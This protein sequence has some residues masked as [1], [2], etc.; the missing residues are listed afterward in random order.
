MPATEHARHWAPP[1]SCHVITTIL[2]S[3]IWDF[4]DKLLHSSH[5]WLLGLRRRWGELWEVVSI[6]EGPKGVGWIITGSPQKIS[7]R[8]SQSFLVQGF[9]FKQVLLLLCLMFSCILSRL[10]RSFHNDR[11]NEFW[12]TAIPRVHIFLTLQKLPLP[13]FFLLNSAPQCVVLQYIALQCNGEEGTVLL[14]N[15]SRIRW[16]PPAHVVVVQ[17]ELARE[18]AAAHAQKC[19][20]SPTNN[21]TTEI[22]WIWL[23]RTTEFLTL[24]LNY[25]CSSP[26]A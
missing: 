18:G 13:R 5:K 4:L 3:N 22:D 2:I 10:K 25:F 11:K 6:V 16:A 1:N 15:H 23:N 20:Y 14:L 12:G 9:S 17:V 21:W 8:S 7:F 24:P 26:P 19:R